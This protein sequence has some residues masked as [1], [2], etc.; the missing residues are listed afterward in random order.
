MTV[1]EPLHG[2]LELAHDETRQFKLRESLAAFHAVATGA[3]VTV[4]AGAPR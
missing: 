1:V 3:Q 4:A 2:L